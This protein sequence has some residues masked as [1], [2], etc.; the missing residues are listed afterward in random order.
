MTK[1][2]SLTRFDAAQREYSTA[3]LWELFDGSADAFNI[4]HECVDRHAADDSRAAVRI[5]NGDGSHEILTFRELA[6]ES[7]R[8]ANWLVASGIRKGD[9]IAFMLEPSRAFYVSLFGAL[10]CGAISV[11]MFTLFGPEGLKLRLD[12]CTPSLLIVNDEKHGIA[13]DAMTSGRVIV[14]HD[15]LEQIGDYPKEHVCTTMAS[16]LAVFQYTSGTTRELPAAVQHSHRAVVVLMAAALYGTGIRPGDEFFCPSS[17]AWGHGLWHGTLAPLALGVTTG[18]CAGRFDAKNLIAAL[19]HFAITNMSAAS[20]HYRMIRNT[21]EAEA[22]KYSIKKLSYTGEPIDPEALEYIQALFGVPLC[23]MYGTTEIGVVL[24]N[25]PGAEDFI[26]KDGSLGKPLP[27]MRIEIRAPDGTVC[28]PNVKGEIMLF[29]KGEWLATK[30]LGWS[31]E[32]GYLYH[33]GRADDVIISAGWTM[34]AVE[35][36]QTLLG[37][38]TVKEV[39]VIGVPD[40][41]RGLVVKAFIVTDGAGDRQ[42]VT[43]LQQFTRERLSMHEYPRKIEFVDELIK[44]PAGKINRK[45]LRDRE[46]LKATERI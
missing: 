20:T 25:Y 21:G 40:D 16:D 19:E 1:L 24:A 42:Q 41:L 27:G 39:A 34:S 6:D 22:H 36:E 31:D 30:D 8:L 29:R 37:H 17:P 11:P 13:T 44:T 35:I 32:D 46:A 43:E 38:P 28:P 7:G 9:R 15:L 14:D 23:S 26:V 5:V 3:K 33:G 45:A 18:A 10:K 2:S 12:D 4:A